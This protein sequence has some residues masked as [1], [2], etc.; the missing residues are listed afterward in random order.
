[1]LEPIMLPT[2]ISDAPEV[3]ASILT[4]SS[5]ILVP[6]DTIVSP[7]TMS[8]ILYF[9]AMEADPATSQSAPL[10]RITNPIAKRIYTNISVANMLKTSC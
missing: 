7:I 4:M 1:M 8:D 2:A 10:I 5:G 6:I 9:L 3:L